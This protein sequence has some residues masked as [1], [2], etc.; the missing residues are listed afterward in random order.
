VIALA[1]ATIESRNPATGG[2]VFTAPATDPADVDSAVER[3]AAQPTWRRRPLPDRQ[4][5]LRRFAHLVESAAPTGRRAARPGGV[6]PRDA[7]DRH[8]PGRSAAQG[9]EYVY[10]S[11][12]ALQ[13]RYQATPSPAR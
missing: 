7:A 2:V 13:A 5:L 4:A 1:T 10:S 12:T 11:L 6:L 3:A 8:R 9:G